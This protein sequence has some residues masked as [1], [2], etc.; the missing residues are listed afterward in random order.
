MLMVRIVKKHSHYFENR[1][2]F[3]EMVN[4]GA[5]QNRGIHP[6]LFYCGRDNSHGRGTPRPY[7][8]YCLFSNSSI[9]FS[10]RSTLVSRASFS[11]FSS[12]MASIKTGVRLT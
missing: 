11:A 12:L 6:C 1:E 5:K 8:H 10:N 4:V 3:L 9:I 7:A 2:R